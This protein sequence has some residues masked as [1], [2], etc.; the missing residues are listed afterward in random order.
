MKQISLQM[1]KFYGTSASV[2]KALKQI[3]KLRGKAQIPKTA[4]KEK[5]MKM[6]EENKPGAF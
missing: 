4:K 6:S 3:Y 2:E 1:S 5:E